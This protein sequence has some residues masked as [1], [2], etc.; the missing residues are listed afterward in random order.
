MGKSLQGKE[1]GKGINQMKDGRYRG[2]YTDEHGK[3]GAIYD[4]N[5]AKLKRELKQK[6]KEVLIKKETGDVG[7]AI[8]SNLTLNEVYEMWRD[9]ELIPSSR[10]KSTK[11]T[12]MRIYSTHVYKTFGKIKI[13]EFDYDILLR[14]LNKVKQKDRITIVLKQIFEFAV[15]SK[16]ITHN[17]AKQIRSKNNNKSKIIYLT[18]VEQNTLIEYSRKKNE[19]FTNIFIIALNTGMRIGE[20]AGL[21]LDEL[22]IDN[23]LL[24]VKHQVQKVQY[25][26]EY[27]ID[28]VIMICEKSL[29]YLDTPK[30]K[31][32][33]RIVPMNKE[34]KEAILWLLDH[35]NYVTR[36]VYIKR[37]NV[38]YQNDEL[39]KKLI[40][41]YNGTPIRCETLN[42]HLDKVI[43]NILKDNPDFRIKHISVHGLRHSFAT[44]CLDKNIN[45][46]V[47]QKLL[48]HNND[49][50]TELYA[51]VP[52]KKII[53][54]F[55]KYF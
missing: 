6:Q 17:C 47:I 46:R 33:I 4:K 39:L 12:Y 32:S 35:K 3:R 52:D 28:K 55:K 49:R 2:R 50:I 48:G 34:S 1:L 24:Y 7:N 54:D 9:N 41:T 18:D 38:L 23:D 36:E 26:Y 10:K 42:K 44:R 29:F 21:T 13:C 27:N 22:D 8:K 5:L 37:R 31:K 43:D 30:S 15:K 25:N 51:H 40:I 11:Y 53:E 20:I 19:Y 45:T 16:I 14:Y